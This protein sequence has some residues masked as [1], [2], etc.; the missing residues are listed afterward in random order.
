MKNLSEKYSGILLAGGK[1][2]RMGEDKAFMKYGEYFLYEY[3]LSVLKHFSNNILLS[4]SNLLFKQADCTI[5]EDEMP[6]LGPIGG[7]FSCL[8]Q[9]KCQNAIVLPCDLPLITLSIIDILIENSENFDITI[10]LN[11]QNLP[12]PLVGI[13]NVA[14][15]PFMEEMINHG[16]YKMQELLS[17]VNTRFVPFPESP[18][19][20]FQNIN[21]PS[22]FGSL[23]L[24]IIN[25]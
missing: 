2:S 15:I 7:I 11:R 23:P 16:N 4:S 3:S 1:S 19:L 8:K 17:K 25:V 20:S 6:G 24:P 21:Y 18:A 9:I 10:A 5:V 14:V 12:E 13:Y 22:D